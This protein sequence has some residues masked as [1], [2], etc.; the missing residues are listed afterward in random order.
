MWRS[1]DRQQL[2]EC[3]SRI[4]TRSHFIKRI[5]QMSCNILA[6]WIESFCLVEFTETIIDTP[7]PEVSMSYQ[8]ELDSRKSKIHRVLCTQAFNPSWVEGP[9]GHRVQMLK[10]GA[11]VQ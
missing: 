11:V 7:I 8:F 10:H 3:K 1:V 2:T 4:N 5:A 6:V 9:V